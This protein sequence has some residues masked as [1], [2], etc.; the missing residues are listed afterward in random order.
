MPICG[1][2]PGS[3]S[4]S[5]S[6][7]P[8]TTR[9]SILLSGLVVVAACGP[10]IPSA[11]PET[12]GAVEARWGPLAV[13]RSNAAMAARNEGRLLVTDRCTFIERDDEREFLAWPADRTVWDPAIAAIV[14]RRFSGEVVTVRTGDR[15]VLGGGGS[16]R[17]E[18]G[19]SGAQWASRLNWVVPPVPECLVAVRFEVSDIEPP[20]GQ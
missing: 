5:P 18:D 17:A 11:A 6:D 2:P 3:G 20:Q 19:L 7:M 4:L 9:R 16:S 12:P 14:F 8:R 13:F 10:A 15:V 1:V